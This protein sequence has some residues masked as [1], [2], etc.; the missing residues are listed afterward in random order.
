MQAT[1]NTEIQTRRIPRGAFVY[2]AREI[3][4]LIGLNLTAVYRGS[5]SGEIPSIRLQGMRRFVWPKA[6]IDAWLATAGGSVD[7]RD[8][9]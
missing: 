2:T 9:K 1:I 4:D 5:N 8:A 6:A 7:L 3:A